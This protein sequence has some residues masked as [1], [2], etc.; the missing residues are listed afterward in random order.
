M[1]TGHGLVVDDPARKLREKAD[2]VEEAAGRVRELHA[3]GAPMAAIE[4]ALFR[5]GRRWERFTA[6]LTNGQFSRLNFVRAC[7]EKS[8]DCLKPDSAH[9]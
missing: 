7:L 9:C 1:L 5:N 8:P 3:R 6:L 4:R 2:L